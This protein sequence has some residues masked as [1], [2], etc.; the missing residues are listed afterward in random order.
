[1]LTGPGRESSTGS[2][3]RCRST[4]K[5][6]PG[7]YSCRA[8]YRTDCLPGSSWLSLGKPRPERSAAL[9]ICL[10][11]GRARSIWTRS[12]RPD[13]GRGR[14]TTVA[15]RLSSR[16]CSLAK[17]YSS[18]LS[19]EMPP[20]SDNRCHHRLQRS[21]VRFRCRPFRKIVNL[22]NPAGSGCGL[23]FLIRRDRW[24]RIS[25]SWRLFAAWKR[26]LDSSRGRKK[27]D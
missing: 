23:R 6:S 25:T 22:W 10:A 16:C 9:G 20:G 19:C 4:A 26:R 11:I 3:I 7:I 14:I 21:P 18:W 8:F 17:I 2:R 15:E 5:S 1:M 27:N 12:S 24:I 13:N